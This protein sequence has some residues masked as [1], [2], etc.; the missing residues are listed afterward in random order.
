MT[1]VQRGLGM[2]RLRLCL[3]F[4]L[5]LVFACA[6]SSSSWAD[7]TVTARL[8]GSNHSGVTGTA[9]LTATDDGGLKVVIHGR[10]FVPGI[11]HA[12]HI[13]G[14]MGGGHYMCPSSADDTD[15]DGLLTN[16]E[17]SGEYGNVFF[18]LT[19]RGDTSPR[20]GLALDRMP[21]ADSAGHL[22]YVRTFSAA[23]LPKGLLAHLSQVH[24]VQHGIDVNNNGRY[25][26]AG[27]GVSTFAKNL[28]VNGVPEE[29][30]D[31]ASCGVVTGAM[32]PMSPKGGVETG[33]GTPGPVDVPVA[34]AGVLLVLASLLALSKL[35][36]RP[37]D[38]R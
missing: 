25:D 9:S 24:V 35:R 30:T 13:H 3:V 32:A 33:G 8:H 31:P 37:L 12:Q 10:G 23:Q 26:M 16:E 38:R 11:P 20:S 2:V 34:A 17:A 5:S 18:A 36:G 6:G 14:S 22:D 7:T 29:A 1:L 21:V 15:G 19:T 4:F 28:G 27:A